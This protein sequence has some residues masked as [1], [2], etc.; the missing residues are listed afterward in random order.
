VLEA[1]SAG[2]ISAYVRPGDPY[3]KIAAEKMTSKGTACRI[4]DRHF[5]IFGS[6]LWLRG[7]QLVYP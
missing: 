6:Q 2:L 5:L 3:T 1:T 4:L 7:L